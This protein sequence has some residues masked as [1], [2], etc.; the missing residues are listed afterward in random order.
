MSEQARNHAATLVGE[1]DHAE[2]AVRLIEI[3]CHMKRPAGATGIEALGQ[4]R[5]SAAEGKIPAYIVKD[6]EDMATA[7]IKYFGEIVSEMKQTN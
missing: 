4:F 2:L 5:Q 7:S 6:F 1:I 3:G